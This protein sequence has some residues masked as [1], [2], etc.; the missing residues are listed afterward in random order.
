MYGTGLEENETVCVFKEKAKFLL[1]DT[2]LS[3]IS[4]L[5]SK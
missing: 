4:D 5:I 2:L 1:W 3:A